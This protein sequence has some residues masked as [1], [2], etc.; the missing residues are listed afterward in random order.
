VLALAALLPPFFLARNGYKVDVFEKNSAPGGRCS[1]LIRNGYRFDLG[2]SMLIM[3]GIYRQVFDSL[4]IPLFDDPDIRPM[5][6]LYKIYFDNQKVLSFTSSE[7]EMQRQLEKFEPG[8]FKQA[9]RYVRQ[10]YGFYKTGIN[11]LIGRNYDHLFQFITPKNTML[12]FRLK[13]F[14]SNYSYASKF[15]RVNTFGWPIPFRTSTLAKAL[16]MPLHFF[17]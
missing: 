12:L 7:N 5:D 16:L 11:E 2:A 8:S 15:L 9:Q 4:G 10:G 6:E 1:Q 17:Q 3:P 13:T 14:I